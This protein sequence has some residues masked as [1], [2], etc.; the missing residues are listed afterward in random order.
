MIFKRFFS[1]IIVVVMMTSL[2]LSAVAYDL[3]VDVYVTDSFIRKN[4]LST[5]EK[6]I[7]DSFRIASGVFKIAASIDM[8]YTFTKNGTHIIPTY[9][10]ECPDLQSADYHSYCRCTT[11]SKCASNA[12]EHHT[13]IDVINKE[14]STP[15][16][17]VKSSLLLTGSRLCNN[18]S[19]MH[20]YIYG[21]S[22]WTI[23]KA[24]VSHDEN[25]NGISLLT[26]D[27]LHELGHFYK[28]NDHYGS[29][30]A[31]SDPDCI[32]GNNR[33]SNSVVS[34]NKICSDCLATLR[35]NNDMYNQG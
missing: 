19:G 30:S 7:A 31:G 28:V 35:A 10:A 2:T 15:N 11:N 23:C 14:V 29:N 27:I 20:G 12:V 34:G 33:H 16:K 32:W 18:N 17:S 4:S 25:S 1:L 3:S 24:L 13:S 5:F 8:T 6:E 22:Y 9:A 26:M 21:V